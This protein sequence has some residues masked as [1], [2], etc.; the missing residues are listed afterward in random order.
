MIQIYQEVQHIRIGIRR[1][2]DKAKIKV[3]NH[4]S[5]IKIIVLLLPIILNTLVLLID[6]FSFIMVIPSRYSLFLNPN[7]SN[8]IYQLIWILLFSLIFKGDSSIER[9]RSVLNKLVMKA[10]T[11]GYF[12]F[13]LLSLLFN[14]YSN[15]SSCI[16]FPIYR[17]NN[18]YGLEGRF[19]IYAPKYSVIFLEKI[20][21]EVSNGISFSNPDISETKK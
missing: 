12:T 21:Y 18:N 6:F 11:F 15:Q 2:L 9:L 1:M 7:L 3:K 4:C 16:F 5:K 20:G 14:L 17:I 19:N 8:P 10:L 13:S